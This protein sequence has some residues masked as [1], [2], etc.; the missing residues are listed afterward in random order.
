VLYQLSYSRKTI[1]KKIVQ[2]L[3]ACA[4]TREPNYKSRVINCKGFFAKQSPFAQKLAELSIFPTDDVIY[5]LRC[6]RNAQ[7][8]QR[9]IPASDKGTSGKTAPC[10]YH[11]SPMAQPATL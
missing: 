2:H 9:L 5:A 3:V 8:S 10:Q 6:H 4:T 7:P 11:E 1:N